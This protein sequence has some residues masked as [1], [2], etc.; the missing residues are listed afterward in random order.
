MTEKVSNNGGKNAEGA[1]KTVPGVDYARSIY[2]NKPVVASKS[3]CI[4]P[5]QLS[6]ATT[7]R[8][9]P[10]RTWNAEPGE[11]LKFKTSLSVPITIT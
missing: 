3:K 7:K 10:T 8:P 5:K 9:L 4:S 1:S 6:V 11:K 2:L